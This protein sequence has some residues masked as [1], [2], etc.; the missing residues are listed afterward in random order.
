MRACARWNARWK[1]GQNVIRTFSLFPFCAGAFP[2]SLWGVG[3]LPFS[4]KQNV[5]QNVKK[6]VKH[7]VKQSLKQSVKQGVKPSAKHSVTQ[8]VKQRVKQSV[9]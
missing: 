8:S 4:V 6:S 2:F 9:K 3:G 1:S 7:S 5:K